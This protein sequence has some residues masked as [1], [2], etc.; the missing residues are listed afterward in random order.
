MSGNEILSQILT[1]R[2]WD[3]EKRER[4]EYMI[5]VFALR[6]EKV[7]PSSFNDGRWIDSG[8]EWTMNLPSGLSKP[9]ARVEYS[10]G[11]GHKSA[12]QISSIHE[13]STLEE[14]MDLIR[15]RNRAG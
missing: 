5:K 10:L 14:A 7:D 1:T 6:W 2:F 13:V 11:G 9:G 4:R 8:L 15:D 12:I 3:A